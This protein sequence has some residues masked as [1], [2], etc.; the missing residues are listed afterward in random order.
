MMPVPVPADSTA[1]RRSPFVLLPAFLCLLALLCLRLPAAAEITL[2]TTPGL[3]TYY[4]DNRWTPVIVRVAGSGSTGTG[5]LELL[6]RS[7]SGVQTYS[8]SIQM[9]AGTLND[10]YTLL[11]PQT[12][13]VQEVT[14]QIKLD[15]RVV[16]TQKVE[17]AQ[18]LNDSLPLALVLTQDKSGLAQVN[19]AEVGYPHRLV[20]P[21]PVQRGMYPSGRRGYTPTPLPPPTPSGTTNGITRNALKVLYPDAVSLPDLARGYEAADVVVLG[22]FSLDLLT[23]NEW[24]AVRDWVRG[25]GTLLVCGGA[26]I[27]RLKSAQL[28]DLLPITP[29]NVI[30]K[31][32]LPALGKTYGAA[33]KLTGSPIIAGTLTSDAHALCSEDKLPLVAVRRFGNGSV[34]FTAFDLL[35]PEFRA[36]SGQKKFW[37]TVM[38]VSVGET[39]LIQGMKAALSVSPYQG[40]GIQNLEDALAGVKSSEAPSFLLIGVFLVAYIVCLVPLNYLLLRKYDRREFAW[41]SVPAIILLFAG[42][43][44][45]VGRASKSGALTLRYGT[46]IEGA[47][48]QDAWTAYTVASVF[49]PGQRRYD[50]AIADP[51]ATVSELIARDPMFYRR[52]PDLTPHELTVEQDQATVVRDTLINMWDHRN[53]G[54]QS[55]VML[56]GTVTA[57]VE[58]DGTDLYKVRVT[59][60]TRFP[61]H[62]CLLAQPGGTS[63]DIGELKPGEQSVEKTLRLDLPVVP[64][65]S[66][67]PGGN[68]PTMPGRGRMPGGYPGYGGMP[69]GMSRRNGINPGTPQY[70]K[71]DTPTRIEMAMTSLMALETGQP[72]TKPLVFTGWF[73]ESVVGLSVENETPK[74]EGVNLLVVHLPTPDL[75]LPPPIPTPVQ[76]ARSNPFAPTPGMRAAPPTVTGPMQAEQLNQMAYT[77][78]YANRLEEA[79]KTAKEAYALN[80]ASGNIADTV[81]EMYQR[82]GDLKQAA[83]YYE[84]SLRLSGG[85]LDPETYAK[86]GLV[87]SAL[88]R[89]PEALRYLEKGTADPSLWQ[90]PQARQ[91]WF[92][93]ADEE[94]AK[95]SGGRVQNMPSLPPGPDSRRFGRTV[96]SFPRAPGTNGGTTSRRVERTP[97]GGYNIIEERQWRDASGL[98]TQ[99]EMRHVPPGQPTY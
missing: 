97:D 22:D 73:S 24:N 76:N 8:R 26:D 85:A 67:M 86:Y 9:H 51:N 6:V 20:S 78:A 98:H 89:K 43:A 79:L 50:V 36:W 71:Y 94:K 44:Y 72:G 15:G 17:G 60:N 91:D 75:R 47:A 21:V 25:G 2:Q 34:L 46:V 84:Q 54:F 5:R 23:E 53:F 33:P 95:L 80:P 63:L 56:G 4:R 18:P 45:A 1:F 70:G 7:S 52:Q 83:N 32:T 29:T 66:G 13:D 61:L 27:N 14:A 64:P 3:E 93:K 88:G 99:T 38:R 40:G 49:S 12:S 10:R 58:R 65:T 55:Q 59:N 11:Y 30:Q 41:L 68:G 37:E 48:N 62:N 77:Y 31:Q 16:A 74:V 69:P 90:N 82:K 19:G 96:P 87:L 39:S 92:R 57:T 81:A 42:G 28:A 35:A